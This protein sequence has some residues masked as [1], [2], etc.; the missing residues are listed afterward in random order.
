MLIGSV[1]IKGKT[2][3]VFAE[4]NAS[5]KRK[6]GKD[7]YAVIYPEDKEFIYNLSGLSSSI[8][9]HEVFHAYQWS[10]DTEHT[11]ELTVSDTE[12]ISCTIYGNND[13][14]L[15]KTTQEIIDLFFKY[16]RS[17]K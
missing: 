8:I 10:T 16:F 7:C 1:D 6:H 12:E 2:W 17:L 11:A 13:M 4:K 15:A 3:Q 5:F 9:K 14:L